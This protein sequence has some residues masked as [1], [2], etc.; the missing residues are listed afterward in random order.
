[1]NSW[2]REVLKLSL[3]YSAAGA[4]FVPAGVA[5]GYL[6]YT[7]RAKLAMALLLMGIGFAGAV[8]VWRFLE[9][10]LSHRVWVAKTS[11]AMAGAFFEIARPEIAAA[12]AGSL[13][14]VRLE[15]GRRAPPRAVIEPSES[16]Q[17]TASPSIF[18][19]SY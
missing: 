14:G 13:S 12:V 6:T 19:L 4:A 9:K 8:A 1:M 7:G 18:I 3:L 17:S 10:R 5:Y 11:P 15:F 16:A 2:W